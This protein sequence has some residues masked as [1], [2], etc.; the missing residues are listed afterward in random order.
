MS[1]QEFL[2]RYLGKAISKKLTVFI[3]ACFFT[4]AGKL[5]GDQWTNIAIVYIG[6]V[7]VTETWLKLKDKV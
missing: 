6:A 1:R 2:D 3:I 4:Y 5:T 7:A